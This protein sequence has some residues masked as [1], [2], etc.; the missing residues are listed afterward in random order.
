MKIIDLGLVPDTAGDGEGDCDSRL[1]GLLRHLGPLVA[2]V[3]MARRRFAQE[4]VEG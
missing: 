4:R 3:D 2:V 1:K